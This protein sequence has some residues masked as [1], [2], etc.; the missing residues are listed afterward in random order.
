MSLIQSL[1]GIV[2][3][4]TGVALG[5]AFAVIVVGASS[6]E[7]TLLTARLDEFQNLKLDQQKLVKASH[8]EFS[9]QTEER[10]REIIALHNAVQE[11]PELNT[12]MERYSSWWSSLSQAEWDSF[13][14]MDRE[15]Q[16]A[17][18][19]ARID[20]RAGSAAVVIVEFSGW[21][22]TKLQPLH[23]TFDE[24]KRIVTLFLRDTPI[25][26]DIA[27]E[28]R[29]LRS[30]EHRSLAYSLWLFDQFQ[31]SSD[32]EAL[33][34]RSEQVLMSIL[35]NVQDEAW[36]EP[37]GQ[38]VAEYSDRSFFKFWMCQNLLVILKESTMVLGN[39]LTKEFPVSEDEILKS[40]VSMDD[41]Q[42]QYS[43]MVMPSN[44]ARQRLEFLSQMNRAQTPEQKLLVKF[45]SFARERERIIG[46][47]TFQLGN[48]PNTPP[49]SDQDAK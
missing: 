17:F 24:C 18:A 48:R 33:L 36:S 35:E 32:R 28:V 13:P 25:P 26:P 23:L 8:A 22:Q 7:H 41:K 14:A 43:L 39:R 15:Q 27:T 2:V 16:I 29:Q 3:P 47:I 38:I 1:K 10:R 37:F 20:K 42:R 9:R 21:G 12:A 31:N 4:F 6:Q 45:I 46:A 34:Q 49:Q 11:N 44:E 40:F 19:K 30:I 5:G